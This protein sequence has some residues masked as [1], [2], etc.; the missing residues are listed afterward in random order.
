MFFYTMRPTFHFTSLFA[1]KGSGTQCFERQATHGASILSN[2][3]PS[4]SHSRRLCV[5]FA[6]NV[7]NSNKPDFVP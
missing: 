7:S 1:N 2:A 6:R 3:N 5:P 4:R